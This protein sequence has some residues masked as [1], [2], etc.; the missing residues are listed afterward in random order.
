MS[1]KKDILRNRDH[2]SKFTPRF[3][4]TEKGTPASKP[5]P[6]FIRGKQIEAISDGVILI[7]QHYV[8][9]NMNEAVCHLMKLKKAGAMGKKCFEVIQSK[10]CHTAR[11]PVTKILAGKERVRSRVR[12]KLDGENEMLTDVVATPIFGGRGELLAVM[13]RFQDA[14]APRRATRKNGGFSKFLLTSQHGIRNEVD[15]SSAEGK[16][17]DLLDGSA[18]PE[19][20]ITSSPLG[21]IAFDKECRYALW[22]PSVEEMCGIKKEE[23]LGRRA[24]DIFT[25]LEATGEDRYYRETLAGKTFLVENRKLRNPVTG[26]EI[27]FDATYAPLRDRSGTIIGGI[28]ILKD[29]TKR[30]KAEEALRESEEQYRNLFESSLMAIFTLDLQ[31]RFTSLNPAAL[32]VLG[33]PLMEVIG[34]SFR[35]HV[36]PESAEK[37]VQAFKHMYLTDHPIRN[38]QCDII[39]KSGRR[40]TIEGNANPIA[41][42]GKTVGFQATTIDVTE[43]TLAEETLRVTNLF[44]EAANRHTQMEHLIKDFLH[45]IHELTGCD[46]VGIRVYD[47]DHRTIC[48]RYVGSPKKLFKFM[49]PLSDPAGACT[50]ARSEWDN[51]SGVSMPAPCQPAENTAKQV[52]CKT[53]KYKMVKLIPIAIGE[54]KLG[55]IQVADEKRNVLS[56]RKAKALELAATHIGTAIVRIQMNETVRQALQV[57]RRKAAESDALLESS[58]AVLEY[59]KFEAAAE[60]IVRSCMELVSASF[61]CITLR[62][63]QD[64][65]EGD[66]EEV[67]VLASSDLQLDAVR[68]ARI[69]VD[70]IVSS[71]YA[72]RSSRIINGLEEREHPVLFAETIQVQNRL[73]LP[74]VLEDDVAGMLTLFNKP[75]GFSQEDAQLAEAFAGQAVVAL[76]NNRYVEA[77]QRSESRYKWLS[78][79]LEAMV[80][81]K[82]AELQETKA[83]ASIGQMVSVVAHEIRNPLQNIYMGVDALRKELKDD[84]AKSE[85]LDEVTY[86][87]GMLNG[88]VRELL[89]YSKP[90]KLS[91]SEW[92]VQAVVSHA[93]NLVGG[94]LNGITVHKELSQ[95]EKKVN[96]DAEKIAQVLVNLIINAVDAMPDGGKLVISSEFGKRTGDPFLKLS[97]SDTGC[98]ID[99][100]QLARIAEPFFTTKTQGTGLGVAICKKIV[101]AHGGDLHFESKKN[102]GTTVH[103]FLPVSA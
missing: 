73:S 67:V 56:E 13:K 34:K 55:V 10:H 4:G 59:K 102:I 16:Q 44:L 26:R 7:D 12:R 76:R 2:T 103:V 31:G 41:L 96:L 90:V 53:C 62:T 98:G 46:A 37:V 21:V 20:L 79:G 3:V 1:D 25:F 82:V 17:E 66:S 40:R 45:L 14:S 78:A 50:C 75:G 88:I 95:P 8:I 60:V 11:C 51:V 15:A 87:V 47:S 54:R 29:I 9:R 36:T 89:D 61:G 83:L 97:V 65:H 84:P 74:L 32:K 27:F 77:L 68:G 22:N 80:R 30:T 19:L 39:T 85:I 18:L 28:I 99:A 24:F 101:E 100:D 81:K 57:S 33:Y 92:T 91:P 94:R 23:V 49:C 52:G 93:L 72:A 63:E 64:E 6:A 70:E 5:L 43:R 42:G 38:M 58:R 71:V 69:P 86:G 48:Q 35:T